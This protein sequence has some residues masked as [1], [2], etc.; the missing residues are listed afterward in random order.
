MIDVSVRSSDMN[1]QASF[2][3]YTE[4]VPALGTPVLVELIPAKSDK[5]K[6]D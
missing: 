2:E 6:K 3:P 4:R 5:T 1:S